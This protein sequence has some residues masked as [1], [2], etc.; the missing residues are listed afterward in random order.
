MIDAMRQRLSELGSEIGESTKA[1]SA[2]KA[3]RTQL[4][5]DLDALKASTAAQAGGTTMGG[6][7]SAADRARDAAERAM[8]VSERLTGLPAGET[9]GDPDLDELDQLHR[10]QRINKRLEEIRSRMGGAT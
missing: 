10:Q 7:R 5:R 4:V 2:L 9:G 8:N 1:A 3:T 6:S